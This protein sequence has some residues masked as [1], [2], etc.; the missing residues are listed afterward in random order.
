MPRNAIGDPPTLDGKAKRVWL[1]R[2]KVTRKLLLVA[3]PWPDKGDEVTLN[4]EPWFVIR[5]KDEKIVAAFD[6]EGNKLRQ[7][8]P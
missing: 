6:R 1:K 2:G 3:P 8:F 5:I 4:G 7:V